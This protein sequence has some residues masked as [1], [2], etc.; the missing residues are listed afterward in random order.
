MARR[1]FGKLSVVRIN[2]LKEPGLFSDGGGLYL[3]V[4]PNLTKSWVFRFKEAGKARDMGLGPLHT[5][6]LAEARELATEKRKLRLDG[7]DPIT[8][9]RA[10]RQARALEAV[11]AV[12]FK[13]C[14][15]GYISAHRAGWR[16]AKHAHQW[17]STL[18][19]HAEPIMGK[20]SVQA[21]DT[22][23]VLKCLEPIWTQTPE[24][25]SRLRGRIE[26]ILD[27]ATARGYRQGENPARWRGHLDHL[28]PARSK[29]QRVEHHAALPYAEVPEFVAGLRSR[30]TIAARALEFTILTAART[31]EVFGALWDEINLE[32][33]TWTIPG[34][35][36]KGG[37]EHRAPLSPRAVEILRSLPEDGPRV[38]SGLTEAAWRKLMAQARPDVTIHGF[39]SSFRDWAAETTNYQNHIVEMALAHTIGDAVERAYRRG[40]LFE[41]RTR[42]M[43]A[44]A[45]FCAKPMKAGE[46]VS[47]M[48][49][50]RR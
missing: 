20:L 33:M 7:V 44:W 41:K 15:E 1:R 16:S 10:A 14:A 13:E 8:H 25:A 40:D 48:R 39:R 42:L 47:I 12:T 26:A 28:L 35:R 5:I 22:A 24:T 49:E 3:R 32:L 11:K 6:T 30:D 45:G 4:S 36:M 34:H 27:W 19:A 18:A 9:R 21:I 31:G 23:V 17:T 46:V 43:A 50:P 38:F 2:S 29:V 37:R